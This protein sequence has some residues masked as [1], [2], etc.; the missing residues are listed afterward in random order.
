MAPRSKVKSHHISDDKFKEVIKWLEDG[1]TKKAACDMLGVASNP[2]MER[3][4]QEWKD[5]QLMSAEM[6]KKKRGTPLTKV[7]TGNMI[8]AYLQG[9]SLEDISKRMYRSTAMIR[10]A[11]EREGANLK[12]N[13]K[14]DPAKPLELH[15]PE[16]PEQ[17]LATSFDVGELVWVAAYQCIG[18]IIKLVQPDVYR[19]FLL[20]EA[21]QKFVHQYTWDLGSTKSFQE[22]GVNVKSLGV[23]WT[24][25][26]TYPIINEALEKALKMNKDKGKS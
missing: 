20:G 11:I 14:L 15:P 19:V 1:G 24:K 5:D 12:Y 16:L 25:E 17:V 9:D 3:L 13:E 26:Q 10:S 21:D 7:E 23:Q 2:T 4:I 8:E 6:R 22:L 18:E